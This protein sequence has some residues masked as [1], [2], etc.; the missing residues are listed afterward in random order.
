M[1]LCNTLTWFMHCFKETWLE[2]DDQDEPKFTDLV[3]KSGLTLPSM[4]S[5]VALTLSPII[6]WRPHVLNWMISKER[7]LSLT[8]LRLWLTLRSSIHIWRE[9]FALLQSQNH[10]SSLSRL[11]RLRIWEPATPTVWVILM[12][13]W[14]L[15]R[16]RS[17]LRRTRTI[18][19]DLNPVWNATFE[20]TLGEASSIWLTVWDVELDYGP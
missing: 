1:L 2:E 5:K 20:F 15:M 3:M 19:E 18:Y 8:R 14:F 10:F 13:L 9:L 12:L 7:R 6:S 16:E 17:R 4:P 11:L